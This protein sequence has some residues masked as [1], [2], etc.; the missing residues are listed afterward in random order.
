MDYFIQKYGGKN[1]SGEIWDGVEER[2][3]ILLFD[4]RVKL[5]FGESAN[6]NCPTNNS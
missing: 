5:D 6:S 4:I 1:R 2:Q 3:I